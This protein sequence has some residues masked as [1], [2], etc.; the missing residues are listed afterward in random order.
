VSEIS[1]YLDEDAMSG[2]LVAALRSNGVTTI[3]TQEAGLIH[4]SDEEQLAFATAHK[5]VLYTFNV[6]DFYRLHTEWIGAGR[7]L[8]GMILARQQRYSVGEQLRRILCLRA[9]VTAAG[10]R[11]QAEFLGSWG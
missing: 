2:F 11:N 9:A 3:T 7:D 8:A 6:C 4:N 1:L 5:F 10:M